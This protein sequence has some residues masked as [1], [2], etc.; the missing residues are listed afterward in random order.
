MD[1]KRWATML[2]PLS[3]GMIQKPWAKYL[4]NLKRQLEA[5]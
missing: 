3:R 1:V 5:T 2:Q 4:A